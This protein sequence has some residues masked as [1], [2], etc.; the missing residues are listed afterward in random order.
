MRKKT[1]PLLGLTLALLIGGPALGETDWPPP[2]LEL[3]EALKGD[4]GPLLRS[5]IAQSEADS[6][7]IERLKIRLEFAREREALGESEK[8]SALERFMATYGFAIGAAVG[9][10]V[11]AAAVR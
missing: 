7:E 2:S 6:L 5:L 10:Y 11:G 1:L 4:C 3:D 9:V 8:P